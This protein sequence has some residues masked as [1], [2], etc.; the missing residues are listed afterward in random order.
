MS[1]LI[2]LLHQKQYDLGLHCLHMPI[3]Q[4]LWCTKF[5]DKYHIRVVISYQNNLLRWWFISKCQAQ[6]SLKTKTST[7]IP[8]CCLPSSSQQ[9]KNN[10]T[11]YI[12]IHMHSLETFHYVTKKDPTRNIKHNNKICLQHKKIFVFISTIELP[13]YCW[14]TCYCVY[15][16]DHPLSSKNKFII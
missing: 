15:F 5:W 12:C 2:R 6:L 13:R 14:C 7:F 16:E 4:N 3:C 11:W 8:I 10:V 1:T 9:E